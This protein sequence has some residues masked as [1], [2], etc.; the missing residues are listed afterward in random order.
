MEEHR[1][2]RR[3]ACVFAVACEILAMGVVKK[4]ERN[5]V[6]RIS[7]LRGCIC[8]SKHLSGWQSCKR[9]NLVIFA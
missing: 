7:I 2:G 6:C 8:C 9:A 5:G 1:I 3:F 4:K